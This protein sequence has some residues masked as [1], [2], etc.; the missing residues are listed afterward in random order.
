VNTKE[1]NLD[2][3]IFALFKGD[4]GSGKS[5]AAASFP[6][7]YFMDIDARLK[8]VVNYWRP[9]GR[10]FEYDRFT[11]P[12]KLN[13]KLEEFQAHC[14]YKTIIVDGLTTLSRSIF[15]VAKSMR[16]V[17]LEGEKTKTKVRL[18]A[19]MEL[20]QIDDYQGEV[21]WIQTILN[22]LKVIS[23]SHNINVIMTAHIIT[24]ESSPDIKTG[25]TSI[26]RN[27]LTAGKK[28]AAEVP[29]DFD[30]AWHFD[31]QPS[32]DGGGP[33]YTVI[34]KNTGWDWAK[35]AMNIPIRIDFTNDS[36]YD[37]VME[38]VREANKL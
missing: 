27:I 37:K 13:Q 19:G 12:L 6:E 1:I 17:S 10:E 8:S 31:V 25:N 9:R 23:L 34:T 35:T 18:S 14:P 21:E 3:R 26:S 11:T 30:E 2:E 32:Y 4:P 22:N 16:G 38:S 20:K 7:P 5:I 33:R 24:V 36:L 28:A 15:Q 29:V